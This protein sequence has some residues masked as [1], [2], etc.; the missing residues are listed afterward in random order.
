MSFPILIYYSKDIALGITNGVGICFNTILP[1]LYIFTV[2][3]VF[4]INSELLTGNRL[5]SRFFAKTFNLS[6]SAGSALILSLFCGYP[7]GA[8]LINELYKSQAIS[9]GSAEMLI[10]LSINPGPAFLISAIGS[11]V[12]NNKSIGYILFVSAVLTPILLAFIFR[13]RFICYTNKT[14]QK[15]NYISCF[16]DAI[17]TANKTLAIICGWVIIGSAIIN[18]A[19]KFN[20]SDWLVCLLE[21]SVGVIKGANISIYYVAFLIGFGGLSVVMQVLSAAKDVKPRFII[22]IAVKTI[23]GIINVL[24][25]YI[26]LRLFPQS[27]TTI[28]INNIDFKGYNSTPLA[29]ITL[30]LFI[31]TTL[32][33]LQRKLK[34]YGK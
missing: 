29:S 26:L 25:T 16:C 7:V 27:I 13:K 9:K 1:S 30:M 4:C 31:L 8:K 12:Y 14:S 15:T 23:C 28:N 20:I 32:T 33:F 18:L 34:N 10:C 22:I 2:L 6:E 19:E 24:T 5:F 21:I 17:N 3:S 11:S